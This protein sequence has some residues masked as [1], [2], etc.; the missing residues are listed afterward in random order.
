MRQSPRS[1]GIGAAGRCQ[2]CATEAARTPP[3]SGSRRAE[4]KGAR[5]I[6]GF[7][8]E[9]VAQ[10]RKVLEA[11][12]HVEVCGV[13]VERID[14]DEATSC[15]RHRGDRAGQ[16]IDE[17]LTAEPPPLKLFMQREAREQ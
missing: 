6:G 9:P 3:R 7:H 16:R 5:S 10:P 13:V 15:G 12:M 2:V 8:H 1:Q 11:V 4:P 17:E 14:D